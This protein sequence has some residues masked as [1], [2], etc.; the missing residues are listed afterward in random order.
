MTDTLSDLT[1]KVARKLGAVRESLATGG[2]TTT[3]IDLDHLIEADDFW[4]E[5]VIW[6]LQT[7][8]GLA[9]IKEYSGIADFTLSTNLA[10]LHETLTAA[11]G[12]GDRYAIGIHRYGIDA[13]IGA[14]NEALL[15]MGLIPLVDK[16]ITTVAGQTE[17]A[18]P[19]TSFNLDVRKVSEQRRTGAPD[20]NEWI[21]LY[22]WD[23]E[24]QVAGT[25]NKLI[26]VSGPVGNRLLKIDFLDIHPELFVTTDALNENV[27]SDRVVYDAA[28]F[29][30][31]HR[32][33][34]PADDDPS[35]LK[36][37]ERV[38]T[39]GILAKAEHP[40]QKPQRTT[41]LL[42][43]GNAFSRRSPGDNNPR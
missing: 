8:D 41:K 27:H 26:F 42:T 5:G 6:I 9:P 25:P 11:I 40:I 20:D 14:V 22:D 24:R 43:F 23:I 32:L 37:L 1:Y 35:I 17:Y 18:L 33:Q 38:E 36:Q 34:D 21:K 28:M 39:R 4:V 3:L 31:E 19:S 10:D 15:S 2:S 13:L 29:L 30:L 12:S 7:T 16:S